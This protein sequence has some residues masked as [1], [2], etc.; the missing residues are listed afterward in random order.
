MAIVVSMV[1]WSLT[2]VW[3]KVVY[4]YLGPITTIFLRLIISSVILFSFGLAAVKVIDRSKQKSPKPTVGVKKFYH[5][6][7]GFLGKAL[8][9]TELYIQKVNRKDWGGIILLAFFEPFMYF[10]GESFGM[11]LV[12]STV[13]AVVISTNNDLISNFR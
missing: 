10:M 6:I 1:F 3:Y 5:S 7:V 12:S 4:L 8:D 2:F 9:R 13:G 11:T